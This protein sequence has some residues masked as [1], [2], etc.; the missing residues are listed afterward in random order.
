MKRLIFS[1]LMFALVAMFTTGTLLAKES[2]T[3]NLEKEHTYNQYLIKALQDTN[4]GIRFSAA[5]LLGERKCK[6]AKV[7][8]LDV[9]KNDE[10]YQ[11]RIAAGLALMKIGNKD[12]LRHLKKQA[13]TRSEEHTSELQSH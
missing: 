1:L 6:H 8:L 12:V 11:N 9:L 13:R 7:H 5:K 4:M 3:M 2:R 10:K